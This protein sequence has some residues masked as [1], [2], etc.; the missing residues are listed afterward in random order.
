M[1]LSTLSGL[2]IAH[3]QYMDEDWTRERILQIF[4]AEFPQNTMCAIDG[5]GYSSLS[6]PAYLLLADAGVIDRAL[7]YDLPGRGGRG[8]ILE[9]IGAA[10]LWGVETIDSPRF[11][12]LFKSG[13]VEDLEAIARVFW[14]VRGEELSPE[15]KKENC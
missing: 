4:P 13:D 3:S 7:T 2:Y 12:N 11:V 14:M 9:W 15:Q 6:R 10:Y 1:N 5:L 8:K